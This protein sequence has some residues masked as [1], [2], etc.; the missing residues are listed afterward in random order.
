SAAERNAAEGSRGAAVQLAREVFPE[1]RRD[2]STPPASAG[3]AEDDRPFRGAPK[4]AYLIDHW[5]D[6]NLSDLETEIEQVRAHGLEVW[7][8]VCRLGE[9]RLPAGTFALQLEFLPDAIVLEGEWQQERTLARAL[10]AEH[11]ATLQRVPGALFLEQARAAL[12]LRKLLARENIRHL[13]ATSSRALVTALL[14]R[15]LVPVTLSAA[16][17]PEPSLPR[18]A[19][20][21][22]LQQVDGGR[23]FDPRLVRHAPGDFVIE[24][25]SSLLR[26]MKLGRRERFWNEWSNRLQ[27]FS[28]PR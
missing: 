17:E 1:A 15:R 16:I 27:S 3:F 8:I 28:A 21:E 14:V 26:R 9:D 18:I 5:P 2:P 4:G 25:G 12:T 23:V 6:D 13:H 24:N 22:A 7:P 11:A 10:E 20:K 19:L